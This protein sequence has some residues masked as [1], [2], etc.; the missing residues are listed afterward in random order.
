VGGVWIHAVLDLE[1]FLKWSHCPPECRSLWSAI[2]GV[3]LLTVR[4]DLDVSW[5]RGRLLECGET[6]KRRPGLLRVVG[7]SS[8]QPSPRKPLAA[9]SPEVASRRR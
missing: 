9:N 1:R 2:V 8:E 7:R 4:I 5:S 6:S 3:D